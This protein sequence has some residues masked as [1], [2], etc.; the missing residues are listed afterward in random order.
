M[1]IIAVIF[2]LSGSF[3][4]LCQEIVSGRIVDVQSGEGL[5]GAHTY[6]LNNWRKGAIADTAGRFSLS[7]SKEDLNDSLVVSYVGFEEQI[8]P[9]KTEMIINLREIETVGQT[10]VVTAK[11]LISEEFKY[12]EIK[13][14]DIYTNPA[15][16]ADPI[17]A[18]NSLPASTTT[19]ESANISLRGSSPIE[20]GVFLNSVPIYDAVRYSQL[21]GI[22]T[23]SIFNTAIIKG[24]TVFPGNPPLEFGNTTSGI[25][26]MQTDDRILDGNANS[27]ILSLANI[28]FSR[29]QK[30]NDKQSFKIFTNWQPSG[31][32]KSLNEKALEEIKAFSSND[33][34]VYWYGQNELLNWK[35]LSYSVTE[36]YE[37]NFKHPSFNGIFDQEKQ[38]SFLISSLEKP[39]KIGSI[40]FNS[41]LSISNGN[42]SYSNVAFNV[43]KKDL[44]LGANY[45]LSKESFSLKTGVSYDHRSSRVNGNF[46]E[47]SYA[48]DENHPTIRLNE[49]VRMSVLEGYGYFKYFFSEKI[50][51]GSSV[52]KNIPNGEVR[53]YISG[54][55]NLSYTDD[56]WTITLGAGKYNKHSL[57]ENTGEPFSSE[58]IQKSLDIKREKNGIE[59]AVSIFDK[60]GEINNIEYSARGIELFTDYRFSSKLRAST[61]IT[62]LD[63]SSI[64]G[65]YAYDL[66]Y[67]IRGNLA[68]SPG[69]FWTIESTMVTRQGTTISEVESANYNN[70]LDVY[71]PRFAENLVRLGSYS[72][73]GLSVS[74][75]FTF[76]EKVNVIAFASL[77]NVM[78][79]RNTRSFVYNFDYSE[80]AD[81]FY[82]RRTGYVGAII[83]F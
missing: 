54:Q 81:S 80:R 53:N 7:I 60:R 11:P 8:I 66:S 69:R 27:L 77:N 14:N 18:V 25:I 64:E 19:D 28:G 21:N 29:E 67:F 71:E 48:L 68:Y 22:G 50:A 47:I 41:G 57:L 51:F 49:E 76:S 52:R 30:I 33:L 43:K 83:N 40:G 12:M 75:I 10:V 13:K 82:S 4:A 79:T 46:H 1:K 24:V 6:L 44:F 61:S 31:P 35:V 56:T 78:D 39:F 58:S 63:A 5:I 9:I 26:S 3:S 59:I 34:G 45:L 42:Y 16:K 20:T 23:F 2:C 55:A 32:I 37:F 38:R 70:S 74:K 65:A 62:L 36:E 72:N 73:I 15:A 17:L